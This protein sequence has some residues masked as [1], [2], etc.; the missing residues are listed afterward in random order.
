MGNSRFDYLPR[1]TNGIGSYPICSE[2]TNK[3]NAL[4]IFVMYQ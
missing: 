3:D 2:W 1:K 4:Y